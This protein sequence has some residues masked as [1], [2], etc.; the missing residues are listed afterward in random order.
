MSQLSAFFRHL[1]YGAAAEPTGSKSLDRLNQNIRINIWHGIFNVATLDMVNPFTGIFAMKLGATKFQVALLSSLPA[2]VSLLAMIP[3]AG[4]IDRHARKK[5]LTLC[6]MFAH[7][8][9]FLL[10]ACIPFFEPTYRAT[11]FVTIIGLMNLPGAIGNIAWQ[12]LISKIIPQERRAEAFACRNRA[13]NFVG[14]LLALCSGF[15]LDRMA[16]PIGYQLIFALAF[17]LALVEL[18]VFNKLDEQHPP[19]CPAILDTDTLADE[20]GEKEP[21]G[22]K[23]VLKETRFVR[24]TLA[25]IF[26]YFAWPL[27]WPLFSWYQVK[28]LGANNFWVSLLTIMASGGSL[29]GYGFWVRVI[30]RYGN[31]KTLFFSTITIFVVPAAYAFSHSLYIVVAFNLVTGAIFSGVNLALFNALLEVTP[32]TH[33]ASYI[34]YYNTCITA[35]QMIAPMV[36]MSLLNF[37]NFQW[38][39]IICAIMRIL[40]SCCFWVVNKIEAQEKLSQTQIS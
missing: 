16:F 7:R 36:G 15:L 1:L 6:F 33:K 17:V 24:Y 14:T 37:M 20:S 13:M 26:F 28:I 32:N 19:I 30:N 31:L 34:A 35:A 27:A 11:I 22:L 23:E 18:R 5:R 21:L 39:F 2:A 40:G 25:S 3:G 29:M 8:L 9:F 12:S 10:I 4:F 38:A